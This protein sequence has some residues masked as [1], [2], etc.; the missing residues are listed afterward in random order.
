M[1]RI[2]KAL[3]KK[4]KVKDVRTMNAYNPHGWAMF[5]VYGKMRNITKVEYEK[6]GYALNITKIEYETL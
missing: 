1:T 5:F 2:E 4:V 3:A 6:D